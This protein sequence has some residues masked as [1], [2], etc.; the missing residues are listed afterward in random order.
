MTTIDTADDIG[1]KAIDVLLTYPADP[2]P[3]FAQLHDVGP[4]Y[5]RSLDMWM[6]SDYASVSALLRS[7][8]LWQAPKRTPLDVDPESSAYL[9]N[10][11]NV[12]VYTNPP[13]HTRLRSIL[14]RAFTPRVVEGLRPRIADYVDEH[15][16]RCS[17]RPAFDLVAELAKQVPCQVICALF[18]VPREYED[19][20]IEWSDAI[21]SGFSPKITEEVLRAADRAVEGFD[22][23]LRTLIEDRRAHPRDDV[24]GT[25]VRADDEEGR[26]DDDEIVGFAVQLLT[27]GHE[28]TTNLITLATVALGQHPELVPRLR[29]DPRAA[30]AVV[31]EALRWESPVQ[32]AI[33][34]ARHETTLGSV[35]IAAGQ[36]ACGLLG[37]ANHDP[38]VFSD[39]GVF[40]IDRPS[41]TSHLAFGQGLHFCLG[42]ALARVEATVALTHLF[43]R[44]PDLHVVDEHR[45]WRESFA[46]RG[47]TELR[48]AT[49]AGD[50]PAGA[51]R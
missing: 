24:L 5:S 39:P 9:R 49:A 17:D 23:L 45:T 13:Q 3:V 12:L 36:Q 29:T 41:R 8:D 25:L 16:D 18:G 51:G 33:R 15:L 50:A 7:P 2:Y 4:V 6:F 37:A 22:A 26:L 42:A 32:M 28:T 44:F 14:L 46:L 34:Q 43:D 10:A 31:E 30:S 20:V 1:N 38:S 40:T 35:T 11:R 27:A 47:V 21:S 48:V 19:Q